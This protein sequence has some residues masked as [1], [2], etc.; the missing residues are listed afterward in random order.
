MN[1]TFF[2]RLLIAYFVITQLLIVTSIG[3]ARATCVTPLARA[4]KNILKYSNTLLV[5]KENI[6]L[7]IN[8][9]KCIAYK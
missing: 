5:N 1:F 8:K 9:H 2:S 3:V 7:K 6:L 4:S